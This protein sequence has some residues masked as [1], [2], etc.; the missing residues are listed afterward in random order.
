MK[1]LYLSLALLGLICA[2]GIQNTVSLKNLSQELTELLT[3]AETAALSDDWQSA[4]TLTH[5][6]QEL[7][8]DKNFY[9]YITVQHN[10]IEGVETN[11]SNVYA[12]I[13]GQEAPEYASANGALIAQIQHIY[14]SE[15]FNLENLF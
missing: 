14:E 8:H 15:R 4:E 6:A 5:Q 2:F 12:Y 1:Q 3:Q 9:I 13:D 7:W 11:F 10:Q